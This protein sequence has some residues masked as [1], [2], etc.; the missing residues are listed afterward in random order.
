MFPNI[1]VLVGL[2]RELLQDRKDLNSNCKKK[3]K[4]S[5]SEVM[6]QMGLEMKKEFCVC[7]FSA[8]G[9]KARE[10]KVPGSFWTS[11]RKA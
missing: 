5:P 7:L 11:V 6:G 10:G 4:A 3:A 2:E 9:Q 8:L 1:I